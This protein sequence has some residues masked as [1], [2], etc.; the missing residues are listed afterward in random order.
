M[1]LTDLL[2][3]VAVLGLLMTA[4]LTVLQAGSRAWETGAARVEAQENARVALTRM[5]RDIKTAGAGAAATFAAVTVA[6]PARIVFH[7][8][9]NDDRVIAGTRETITWKLDAGILRR[10]AG[11]G[12]QPIVN[13][14]RALAIRYFDAAGAPA[15]VPE[16][17][18]SVEITLTTEPVSV[19]GT[20]VRTTVSTRVRLRNR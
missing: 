3:S 10:D 19:V 15:A 1:T 14:V 20:G 2:V 6:E 13:G 7:R 16:D 9:E 8:D 4:N 5:A 11:G 18:R 17:V 12:A